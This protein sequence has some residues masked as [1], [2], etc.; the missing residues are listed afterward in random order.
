MRLRNIL[1][2]VALLAVPAV[3]QD[4]HF[5]FSVGLSSPMGGGSSTDISLKDA[6][7]SKIGFTAG[8]NVGIE[9]QGGHVLR[10]R[11]DYTHHNGDAFGVSGADVTVNAF[12]LGADYNYFVS[13][14]ASDGFYLLVGVG[15]ANT[16]V[17]GNGVGNSDN[18]SAF[19]WGAGVGYEFT[20]MVGAEL[21]YGSTHPD[22]TGTTLK[23]DTL[24][25]SVTFR[26]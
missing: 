5:G 1:P 2:L 15:Y 17:S 25:L 22:F 7:D 10:P 24:N 12:Q 9:W 14:K 4:A 6:V 23:N 16:K 13:E 11:L 26:F 18:K 19:A 21:R 8:V 3:A 20:P